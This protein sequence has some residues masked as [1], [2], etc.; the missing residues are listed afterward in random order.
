MATTPTTDHSRQATSELAALMTGNNYC[1]AHR[2]LLFHSLDVVFRG[3][4]NQNYDFTSWQAT[5]AIITCVADDQ[6]TTA[7]S[8]NLIISRSAIARGFNKTGSE[9]HAIAWRL[10]AHRG[11]WLYGRV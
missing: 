9:P 2:A 8:P 6:L 1:C 4:Q 11:F 3:L 10:L 5:G 7:P